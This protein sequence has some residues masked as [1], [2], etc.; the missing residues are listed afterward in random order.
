MC[1]ITVAMRQQLVGSHTV[2]GNVRSV[3]PRIFKQQLASFAPHFAGYQQHDS[4]VKSLS[5][6]LEKDLTTC[7][8]S[9]CMHCTGYQ[10]S[11]CL[12]KTCEGVQELLAFLLDGLHEDLNRVKNKPYIEEPDS[13]GRPDEVVAAEAWRNFK[14]RNDSYIVDHFQVTMHILA[15]TACKC[16]I[17]SECMTGSP[18]LT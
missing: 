3:S 18:P 11:S 12:L 17:S 16:D 14:A 13:D 4:Q 1:S 5:K 10:L 8:Q 7:S 15:Q 6:Q 9:G 2:Q